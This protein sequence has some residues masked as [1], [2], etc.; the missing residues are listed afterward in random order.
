MR[1][2]TFGF[3]VAALVAVAADEEPPSGTSS[4]CA[5]VVSAFARRSAAFRGGCAGA[6]WKVIY[7][8]IKDVMHLLVGRGGDTWRRH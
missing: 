4:S 5:G 2:A 1:H 3:A 8:G 7:G 6:A